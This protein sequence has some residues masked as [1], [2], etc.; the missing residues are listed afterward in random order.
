MKSLHRSQG[1]LSRCSKENP[2]VDVAIEQTTN[3]S[4]TRWCRRLVRKESEP[5]ARHI[6]KG[7][8]FTRSYK[9][10]VAHRQFTRDFKGRAGTRAAL[11]EMLASVT[12]PAAMGAAMDRGAGNHSS[13]AVTNRY[14]LPLVPPQSH[15]YSPAD[16]TRESP[17]LA[18]PVPILSH[19]YSYKA[20]HETHSCAKGKTQP[21]QGAQNRPD[22]GV[23]QT[24]IN[25]GDLATDAGKSRTGESERGRAGGSCGRRERWGRRSESAAAPGHR[26]R[27]GRG[28][29]GSSYLQSP[30]SRS[31]VPFM[32]RMRLARAGTGCMARSSSSQR[33]TS[34]YMARMLRSAASPR[35]STPS[36]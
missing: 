13:H 35:L 14:P 21:C 18:K 12:I 10:H 1:R 6:Q 16:S 9:L 23:L 2:E 32:S 36:R 30:S 26:C 4:D 29:G 8:G 20:T 28:G 19:C 15:S 25:T 7:T 11:T 5:S 3:K 22:I 27:H 34:A 24:T 31:S 17:T 33:A